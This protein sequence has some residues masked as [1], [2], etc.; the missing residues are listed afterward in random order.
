[1]MRDYIPKARVLQKFFVL[2]LVPAAFIMRRL[3]SFLFIALS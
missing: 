3:M 2:K 1:M